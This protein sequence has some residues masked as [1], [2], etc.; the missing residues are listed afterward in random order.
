MAVGAE[1]VID[2]HPGYMPYIKDGPLDEI[3]KANAVDLTSLEQVKVKGHS[4]GSTDLGD[5]SCVM[6]TTSI[7]MG[8][9]AGVGHGRDYRIVDQYT[10]YV[11]PAKALALTTID[12]LAGDASAAKRIIG[13][14]KPSIPRAG[15]A[16]FMR[17]LAAGD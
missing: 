14:F 15:Y 3:L 6:P 17:K 8:G 13:G 7:G 10:A 4:T 16:E 5:F 1:C 12:L 9:V 11:L 2:D